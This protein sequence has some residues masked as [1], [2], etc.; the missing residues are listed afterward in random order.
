[1]RE[2]VE[3]AD[4]NDYVA[5][6]P[7]AIV[8]A[9][10]GIASPAAFAAPLLL[11]IPAASIGVALL[12]AVQIRNSAGGQKGVALA[13]FGA[14][15]AI[16]CAVAVVVRSEVSVRLV[17]RQTTD[18]A[19]QW[20]D[21]IAQDQLNESLDLATPSV[22]RQFGPHLEPGDAA[23]SFD[24][25]V[26]MVVEKMRQDETIEQLQSRSGDL[27]LTDVRWSTP[28][29]TDSAGIHYQGEFSLESDEDPPVRIRLSFLRSEAFEV[30]G[31]AW[32]ISN[33]SLVESQP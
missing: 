7:L 3:L 10:L 33:W 6:N 29:A 4:Q 19:L 31:V 14:G 24:E 21:M 20:T 1:M 11:L 9:L 32:R 22:F 17:R 18:V 27:R 13:R 12:A 5:W 2:P 30:D 23:P 8:A 16:I 15:L 25:L 28:P 26:P